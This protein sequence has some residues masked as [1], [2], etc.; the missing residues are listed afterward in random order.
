MCLR[1]LRVPLTGG[2][3]APFDAGG[4]RF[5]ALLYLRAGVTQRRPLA[6]SCSLPRT[7]RL[8]HPVS[9][10]VRPFFRC[11][12]LPIA[13]DCSSREPT[14][15]FLTIINMQSSVRYCSYTYI[16]ASQCLF[17]MYDICHSKKHLCLTSLITP[18]MP[19]A[20]IMTIPTFSH[21]TMGLYIGLR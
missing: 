10:P 12:L 16:E 11:D 21:R 15:H 4:C 2:Q 20:S 19:Q 1:G 7:T 5:L 13:I 17:I 14:A 18:P 9:Q 3:H 8:L 6:L